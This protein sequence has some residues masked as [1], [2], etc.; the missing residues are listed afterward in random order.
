MSA[1]D[2]QDPRG[3]PS[4]KKTRSVQHNIYHPKLYK[5]HSGLNIVSSPSVVAHAGKGQVEIENICRSH[6]TTSGAVCLKM[7]PLSHIHDKCNIFGA[8]HNACE[9]HTIVFLA[10]PQLSDK[11]GRFCC[12]IS[13]MYC[14][15]CAFNLDHSLTT[16]AQLPQN[17]CMD[18]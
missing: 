1:Q 15:P 13:I 7:H 9:P 3:V 6:T 5:S 11:R 10:Y 18:S 2:T 8:F 4:G 17:T 14:I 16:M 12:T